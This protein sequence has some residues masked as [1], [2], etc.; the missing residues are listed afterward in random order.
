TDVPE[1]E[2]PIPVPVRL[3][4]ASSGSSARSRA[5]SQ[6]TGRSAPAMVPVGVVPDVS[7]SATG[8]A[9]SR[10]N[11]V[12]T[13]GRGPARSLPFTDSTPTHTVSAP[14][15]DFQQLLGHSVPSARQAVSAPSALARAESQQLLAGTPTLV[16]SVET[17]S[18]SSGPGSLPA[19]PVARDSSGS[20]SQMASSCSNSRSSGTE[21]MPPLT[22][23]PVPASTSDTHAES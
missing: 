8:C 5:A 22:P 17:T 9:S 21:E 11:S 14:P 12:A 23:S 10:T 3:G 18:S 13:E 7:E 20:E 2:A 16:G 15:A 1:L 6:V 4:L 19:V